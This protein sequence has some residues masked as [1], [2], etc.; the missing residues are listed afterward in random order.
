MEENYK[1]IACS[2]DDIKSELKSKLAS[3][4]DVLTM[5]KEEIQMINGE[6]KCLND[7]KTESKSKT[8]KLA[9]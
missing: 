6:I 9:Q 1:Q 5:I 3:I 7:Y 2:I 8:D 4:E